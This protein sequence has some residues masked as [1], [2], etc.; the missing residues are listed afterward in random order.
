MVLYDFLHI[1]RIVGDFLK[2]VLSKETSLPPYQHTWNISRN[3]S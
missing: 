1:E 2:Q 3:I